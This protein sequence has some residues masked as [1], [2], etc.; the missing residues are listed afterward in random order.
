MAKMYPTD[1]LLTNSVGEVTV[2]KI[3][4][5]SLN[6]EWSVFHSY[7]WDR[8]TGLRENDFILINQM[9]GIIVV[10][11]KGGRVECLGHGEWRVIDRFGMRYKIQDP[12]V[13]VAKG[14]VKL[15]KELK[16]YLK[17]YQL[18]EVKCFRCVIFPDV[19]NRDIYFDNEN[20]HEITLFKEDLCAPNLEDIL[21]N[22]SIN[23]CQTFFNSIFDKSSFTNYAMMSDAQ[24]M[25]T[26][27]YF[28]NS[29]KNYYNPNEIYFKTMSQIKYFTDQQLNLINYIKLNKTACITGGAGTGK[30]ALA[31]HKAKL[32]ISEGIKTLILCTTNHLRNDYCKEFNSEE[33]I[34]IFTKQYFLKN[35]QMINP[36]YDAIIID[37][38]QDFTEE[39]FNEI[40]KITDNI[41][42]FMDK[43]QVLDFSRVEEEFSYC[44]ELPKFTLSEIL[45]NSVPIKNVLNRLYGRKSEDIQ[46]V[47]KEVELIFLNN[48]SKDKLINFFDELYE[49]KIIEINNYSTEKPMF[50][51]TSS[52]DQSQLVC[53]FDQYYG[54]CREQ[55]LDYDLPNHYCEHVCTGNYFDTVRRLK[56]TEH[57]CVIIYDEANLV[58]SDLLGLHNSSKYAR[59]S[60]NMIS[61][62][63]SRAKFDL[64]III[65]YKSDEECA[66]ISKQLG[67]NY[68]VI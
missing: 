60:K 18:K 20:M 68:K 37:E 13:Q 62:A 41:Y 31:I 52:I 23:T 7:R 8:N 14:Q 56:G 33:N 40:K 22:I 10:E 1:P 53:N 26:L 54:F 49:S 65:S 48:R 28:N 38:G 50:I 15:F 39:E 57:D 2:F 30:T 67:L 59:Y 61:T 66:L 17:R 43:D 44:S 21:I 51:T 32:D 64:T 34:D 45:R 4:E 9:Y 25:R 55:L 47:Q 36:E 42:I 3:F 6:D 5:K 29:F 63:I 11:V 35:I 12:Y 46:T 27:D 16:D 24:Y 19:S 58:K